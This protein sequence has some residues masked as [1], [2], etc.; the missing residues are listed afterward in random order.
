MSADSEAL[1]KR[2]NVRF[3]ADPANCA[4]IDFNTESKTFKCDVTALIFNESYR[5]CCLVAMKHEK[6]KNGTKCRIQLGPLDAINAELKWTEEI[7]P[8][9]IRMGFYFYD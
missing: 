5:G 2:K 3:K 9:I 1:N 4:Q 8:E 7:D 6:L